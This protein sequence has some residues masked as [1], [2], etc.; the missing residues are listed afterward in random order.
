MT[1]PLVFDMNLKVNTRTIDFG[2]MKFHE[3]LEACKCMG[4]RLFI[5]QME[6]RDMLSPF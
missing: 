4:L 1:V 2:F 6:P 5:R 3:H